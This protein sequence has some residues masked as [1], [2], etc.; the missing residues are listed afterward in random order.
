MS[1]HFTR[2]SSAAISGFSM[3]LL[4]SPKNRIGWAVILTL[5]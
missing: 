3:S 5:S 4:L 1:D 2:T